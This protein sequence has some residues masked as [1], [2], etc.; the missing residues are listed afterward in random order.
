ML[1]ERVSRLLWAVLSLS[2]LCMPLYRDH[3]QL[4]GFIAA[5]CCE[6]YWACLSLSMFRFSAMLVGSGALPQLPA[7][8]PSSPHLKQY[9]GWGLLSGIWPFLNHSVVTDSGSLCLGQS[10]DWGNFS[11]WL[12]CISGAEIWTLK[13]AICLFKSVISVTPHH[14]SFLK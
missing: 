7:S 5:V 3:S 8:W 10:L 12:L 14:S 4:K 6:S 11:E 1:V 9:P 2:C 13:S